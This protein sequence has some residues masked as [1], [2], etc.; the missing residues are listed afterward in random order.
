M[1]KLTFLREED[2]WLIPGSFISIAFI[3]LCLYAGVM[4]LRLIG[5]LIGFSGLW[6]TTYII[7][8]GYNKRRSSQYLFTCLTISI[9]LSLGIYLLTN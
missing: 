7:R 3:T 2:Y 6:F 5:A 4:Q 1:I 9:L 8:R